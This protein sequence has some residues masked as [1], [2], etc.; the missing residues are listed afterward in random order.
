MQEVGVFDG[1]EAAAA[2]HG[3]PDGLVR[4]EHADGT[5][6][7]GRELHHAEDHVEVA[8]QPLLEFVAG[9][10]G[11]DVADFLFV[12]LD[13]LEAGEYDVIV[14]HVP[15][16]LDDLRHGVVV[17]APELEGVLAALMLLFHVFDAAGGDFRQGIDENPLVT[18]LEVGLHEHGKGFLEVEQGADLVA[19]HQPGRDQIADAEQARLRGKRADL[20]T[21]FFLLFPLPGIGVV[22]LP[23][24]GT[25]QAGFP[26]S[27]R[28]DDKA[29]ETVRRFR[30]NRL[31]GHQFSP[32]CRIRV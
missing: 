30:G 19:L 16:R 10:G 21:R 18:F 29:A 23:H 14:G 13:F 27:R 1:A 28:G 7:L 15:E 5:P 17:F 25:E 20:L 4:M 2:V 9:D 26:R 24:D 31:Q 12:G 22:F 32:S 11:G 8:G 3:E 6:Y